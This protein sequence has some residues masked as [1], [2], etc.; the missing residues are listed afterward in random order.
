MA[1]NPS[2]REVYQS[3]PS[4]VEV[5]SC[6][7]APLYAFM[8]STV[9]TFLHAVNRCQNVVVGVISKLRGRQFGVPIT[10]RAMCIAL[11]E[12]DLRPTQSPRQ[13]VSGALSPGL[14]RPGREADP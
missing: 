4:R 3:P 14:K 1:V 11:S 7:S 13:W 9:P 5:R 6:T 12:T 8:V 10:A 2:G